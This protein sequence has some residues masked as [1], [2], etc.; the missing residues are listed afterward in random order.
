MTITS[1]VRTIPAKLLGAFWIRLL[2][3]PKMLRDFL[4]FLLWLFRGPLWSVQP[5][6]SGWVALV[7]CPFC[8]WLS[9]HPN[10]R[11]DAPTVS[12]R[13]FGIFKSFHRCFHLGSIWL[14]FFATY[15]VAALCETT[16]QDSGISSS[17][18]YKD[19]SLCFLMFTIFFYK[20]HH[21]WTYVDMHQ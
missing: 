4:E 7:A 13:S 3:V 15:C 14:H 11:S 9:Q 21:G 1:H 8:H 6:R 19:H 12:P 5:C 18:A 10:V 2:Y 20:I 16:C 17:P